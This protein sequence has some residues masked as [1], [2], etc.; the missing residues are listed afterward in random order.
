MPSMPSH[1]ARE[2]DGRAGAAPKHSANTP[3]QPAGVDACSAR[4][5]TN[6]FDVRK[7][8]APPSTPRLIFGPMNGVYKDIDGKQDISKVPATTATTTLVASQPPTLFLK[9]PQPPRTPVPN[10]G[11]ILGNTERVSSQGTTA[12]TKQEQGRAAMTVAAAK[13][14]TDSDNKS[15]HIIPPLRHISEF[16]PGGG[17]S[18]KSREC[19][20]RRLPVIPEDGSLYGI[21]VSNP[22]V[23]LFVRPMAWSEH[24]NQYL[25][26]T[27]EEVPSPP[28]TPLLAVAMLEY[29]DKESALHVLLKKLFLPCTRNDAPICDVL[30]RLFPRSSILSL[31]ADP[32]AE[33]R[34]WFD[35]RVYRNTLRVECLWRYPYPYDMDPTQS[36][37]TESTLDAYANS[38]DDDAPPKRVS[39]SD[40]PPHCGKPMLAYLGRDWLRG[41]RTRQMRVPQGP[42]HGPNEPVARLCALQERH[43]A[44]DDP[45]RDPRFAAILI[46]MA[47][48]HVYPACTTPPQRFAGTVP[49]KIDSTPEFRDV[50][51][52]LMTHSYDGDFIVYKATVTADYL[53]Q[54]HNP[55]K[56]TSPQVSGGGGQPALEIQMTRV[57]DSPR[58]GL[59]ERLAAALGGDITGPVLPASL[60]WKLE[61]SEVDEAGWTPDTERWSPVPGHETDTQAA[62]FEDLDEATPGPEVQPEDDEQV[63]DGKMPGKRQRDV[64]ASSLD[65]GGKKRR[66]SESQGSTSVTISI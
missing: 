20:P 3:T 36:F 18:K 15:P 61:A 58:T 35:S 13:S 24:H 22:R 5:K 21:I 48:E 51:V 23:R 14:A 25:N 32:F 52:R 11:A 43:L 38:D 27:W 56:A 60:A 57:P 16:V 41:F 54:F 9:F 7:Y 12:T 53:R 33:L 45:D 55:L 50:A 42:G 46:A 40:V 34:V 44:P 30:P 37:M 66:L 63:E 28:P 39:E 1:E 6:L 49:P 8:P 29:R 26:I 17:S 2:E 47:Q 10:S 31:R 19:R 59:K 65:G 62:D 64:D 4:R